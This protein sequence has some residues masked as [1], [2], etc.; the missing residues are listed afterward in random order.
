MSPTTFLASATMNLVRFL[1]VG[2]FT[3]VFLWGQKSPKENEMVWLGFDVNIY[4]N[5]TYHISL[6]ATQPGEA[7]PYGAEVTTY[8]GLSTPSNRR[9]RVAVF[10]G[11]VYTMTIGA[12]VWSTAD[13]HFNAPPGYTMYV[14]YDYFTRTPMKSFQANINTMGYTYRVNI[15]LR[16]DDGVSSLPAGF[17]L[18]PEV[19]P[20]TWAVSLGRLLSGHS[21]GTL[22]WRESGISGDLLH[23]MNLTYIDT[24]SNEVYEETFPDGGIKYVDA[25]EV[26]AR[27]FRNADPATGYTLSF[28]RWYEDPGSNRDFPN[29]TPYASYT[30]STPNNEAW[31]NRVRISRLQDGKTETWTLS[32]VDGGFALEQST[33]LRKI[34]LESSQQTLAEPYPGDAPGTLYRRERVSLANGAGSNLASRVD[35]YYRGFTWNEELIREIADPT[36]GGYSG[37]NLITKYTYHTTG[38]H[39]GGAVTKL[40]SVTKPDGSWVRYD[41][42]EDSARWGELAAVYRP[43]K[44]SSPT[45]PASATTGNSQ[46]STFNY[47][48]ER[49]FYQDIPSSTQTTTMGTMTARTD[50]THSFWFNN[51]YNLWLYGDAPMRT[52]T[53]QIY[54]ASGA[55]LTTTR[56]LFHSTIVPRLDASTPRRIANFELAGKLYSQTNPDGTRVSLVHFRGDFLDHLGALTRT[57]DAAST[58]RNDT[59]G[60]WWC[61]SAFNGASTA[62]P[63]SQPVTS[64]RGHN[65]EPVYMIPYRSTRR[66]A[67]RKV[68]GGLIV[69]ADYLYIGSGSYKLISWKKSEFVNGQLALTYDST[70]ARNNV[71]RIA[72]RVNF[73]TLAD[74]TKNEYFFD[75]LMQV[76]RVERKAV[77]V[78]AGLPAQ[79]AINTYNTHDA[80]GRVISTRTVGSGGL[81]LSTS[82]SFN[83]AGLPTA[84]TDERGLTTTLSYANGGRRIT[85]TLPGGATIITDRWLDGQS[86]SVTGT[87]QV[88][89]YN[90]ISVDG[91]GIVTK[92]TYVGPGGAS[93]PRWSRVY[94]DWAGRSFREENPTSS[95]AVNFNKVSVFNTAG[96]LTRV[97]QTNLANTLL[98][99]DGLGQLEYSGLDMNGNG[100]LDLAGTDR[101]TRTRTQVVEQGGTWWRQALTYLYNQEN[102]ANTVT[103]SEILDRLVPYGGLVDDSNGGDFSAGKIDNFSRSYDIFRNETTRRTFVDRPTALQTTTTNA[104]DSPIDEVVRILGGRKVR[105]QTAQNL[106][107]NLYYD[108]LG[109]LTKQ[110]DPRTDPNPTPLRI[111]YY[112]SGTGQTGQ[113]AWRDD[114][115]GNRTSYAYHTTDGRL[116]STTDPFGKKAYTT[117]TLRGQINTQWGDT[118]YPVAHD[119]S[120]FGEQTA[121]A[122]YRGGSGWNSATW[123]SNAG[124]ADP[125]TWNYEA[126]TGLLLS[127][128]DAANRTVAYTYSPRGQLATRTWARGVTTT[129]SYSPVTGEQLGI[130]YSDSTPNLGYAYNRLGQNIQVAD[131]TGTRLIDHCICG[132]VTA[133]TLAAYFGGRKI[134]Y[135]LSALS[136]GVAGRTLGVSLS[137]PN[138]AGGEYAVNYGYD[139]LGRFNSIA[140]SGGFAFTY[141][142]VTPNSNLVS[143]LTQTVGGPS[144]TMTTAFAYESNR[145]LL[146]SITGTYAATNKTAFAYGYDALGRRT[147][148]VQSGEIFSRYQNGGLMTRWSYN[149]RSE[150]TGSQSYYGSNI[151]DLSQPVAA[152]QLTYAFDNIGSRTTTGV[153]G[154]TTGYSNN[155]LNQLTSRTAPA[156]AWVTGL[157]PTAATVS[158]NGSSAGI[159]RQ[160]DYYARNV[161]A[162][163]T[164]PHWQSLT[165]ASTLSPGA[166]YVR[167]LLQPASP[168]AYT[169][170][171]DGNLLTDGAWTYTWDA[172]NRLTSM[173]P[174]AA[175]ET[176]LP[177]ASRKRIDYRYDYL[178][179]RVRK[180]VQTWNGSAYVTS[181]DRKFI[182]DGWNLLTERDATTLS[183]VAN[184]V[185]G[186]DLSRTLQ[187][188]GGVGGLLAVL[189]PNGTAHLTAYDGNG[190]VA[191]LVNKTTGAITA[192][193]EYDAFGQTIRATGA[194]SATN[195]FRFSTKYTDSETGLLYYGRRYYNPQLGRW[196]GRDPIEEKGGLHLYGF[197]GNNGVNRFDVLGMNTFLVWEPYYDGNGNMIGTRMVEAD[198]SAMPPQWR[199]DRIDTQ[200]GYLSAQYFQSWGIPNG[201]RTGNLINPFN[202]LDEAAE[203]LRQRENDARNNIAANQALITDAARDAA[204]LS[205]HVYGRGSLP[206]YL[207]RLTDAE[208]IAK[209]LDPDLFN[210][211][212]GMNAGLYFN[213]NTGQYALAFRGTEGMSGRDW[214]ASGSQ[215]LGISTPQYTQAM[216]LA[217]RVKEVTE[218]RF[219]LTGHS[220]GGGLASAASVVTGASAIT[221]NAAGLN[222][223]TVNQ[224]YG[225]NLNNASNLVTAYYVR[226]EVLSLGQ[227]YSPLPNAA[228]RR[229]SLAPGSNAALFDLH[230]MNQVLLAMGYNR[231]GP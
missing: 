62:V 81:T 35:R 227:D 18:P 118:T 229:V 219:T 200:F 19:N 148:V 67:I 129:Y 71:S 42:Y 32:N 60:D 27:V 41:Y 225:A 20:V 191:A 86:K 220:L 96:Q 104:P 187:D 165:V 215:T 69:E 125:T 85:G 167:G 186:L 34:L 75:D 152:R 9:E 108:S 84:Q 93:S 107:S 144:Q 10:P 63:G 213:A 17:A 26:Q 16:P 87:A 205:D 201:W 199:D 66:D 166:G 142:Y 119:Y 156:S 207:S 228:G 57:W 2:F 25:P 30:I 38:W 192:A 230:F 180:T 175:I 158:I 114:S 121:M 210:T 170:D 196:L 28:Y 105:H 216:N 136:S 109:R 160:G 223:A 162:T 61:E 52:E 203:A 202:L 197:V 184:Y 102:T 124:T 214:T 111:G 29:A 72:G 193:Y 177:A 6:L 169:Y 131:L 21:A 147:S 151:N 188:G 3:T 139:A 218:G 110:T 209:G 47:I 185:W 123:P 182:Y 116:F 103:Q 178:G 83:F 117:Y 157:A 78:T 40:K 138:A 161:A 98:V 174:L 100:T 122:T 149:D 5:S 43:W 99:Y 168:E 37:L 183:L 53:L 194:M 198:A 204:L 217:S 211:S 36:V 82:T 76:T 23:A 95:P 221:F 51:D 77:A 120:V 222:S 46:V 4:A 112:A 90:D 54:T 79:D 92:T 154:V 58:S 24:H 1:F 153:D 135:P 173:Y 45:D 55:T 172:E 70:G 164:S 14:G 134:T 206:D 226:G 7:N 22:R 155:A 80:A 128:T 101:I 88:A 106:T 163:G 39:L 141:N 15:E 146:T 12:N 115:A 231:P 208:L 171:L 159:T 127:K 73:E 133:E 140:N 126:A 13:V 56:K 137:G 224:L 74:G 179:R 150:V 181:V 31:A 145:D 8:N 189:E 190:N 176:I 132:K 212:A 130:A 64:W 50:I 91:N 94:S 49:S 143:S 48:G 44:D 59:A 33:N 65:L 11:R 68:D 97:E 89:Q 195:P 113:V